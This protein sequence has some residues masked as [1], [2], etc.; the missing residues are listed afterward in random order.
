MENFLATLLLLFFGMGLRRFSL[1]PGNAAHTLNLFVIYISLPALILLKVP[2]LSPSADLL[3]PFLMPWLMLAVS[4]LLVLAAGRLFRFSREILGA[5]LLVVPLGNTSFLGIPMV[6]AFFGADGIP[7]AVLYD[8]LGSFLALASYGSMILAV[9]G[10]G[11]RQTVGGMVK[12]VIAFPAFIALV[13]AVLLRPVAWPQPVSAMLQLTAASL[14]PV[15]MV[16]VGLQL[17]L[18]LQQGSLLPFGVGLCLKLAAAPLAALLFCSIFDWQGFAAKVSV[19]EAGMPPMV[20]A[21]AMAS[22]AG[23]APEFTA[24]MVGYG[25]LFSF[26]TLPVLFQFL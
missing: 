3:I 9:Y 16:A 10:S 18:K 1:V 25:I 24:A 14:V 13:A 21:A 26:A 8:Q 4:A 15:V 2:Q 11:K 23:L 22:L 6:S 20:T 12:K 19:F 17:K 5:L 7:Y